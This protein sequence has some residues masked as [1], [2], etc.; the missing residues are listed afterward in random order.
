[1]KRIKGNFVENFCK[2]FPESK[3]HS[4]RQDFEPCYIR[5]GA[6]YAMRRD[7]IVKMKNRE[8]NNSA[9]FI[10]PIEKSI[11]ID[12]K[13]DLKMARTMCENGMNKNFPSKKNFNIIYKFKN[14]RKP[15]LLVTA[16][17]HFLD[18]TKG[19][20]N[21]KYDLIVLK[22]DEKKIVE[23]FL[24]RT[25]IWIC[26]PCP[27]YKIDKSILNIS[28]SLKIIATPS[29]G[30]NHI[31][32]V[33]CKNKNI[34]VIALKGTKFIKSISASSEYTFAM[35]LSSIRKI[36]Q[37]IN[38]VKS[39]YWRDYENL[40]RGNE[41]SN[42]TLGI[43]GYG[44]IG[45]NLARYAKSFKMK[46]LVNDP[47]KK[48]NKTKIKNTNINLLLKNSDVVAVCVHLNDKTRNM[49]N[50][51]FFK[52][53]KKGAIFINSSRGEIV[54]EK[55]LVKYLKNKKIKACFLDVVTNENLEKKNFFKKQIFNYMK[56]N[57]NLHISPHI[58]GLTYESEN[59]AMKSIIKIISNETINT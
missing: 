54:D 41:L 45:S 24:K 10:M 30:S 20:L 33:Y 16:P 47:Y 50:E 59:K 55:I 25:D 14:N 49:V 1:M 38:A 48:F 18:S 3:K 21:K 7:V 46:I 40:L 51:N 23:K 52:K 13:F 44:R 53:M 42:L 27:K 56:Q 35:I 4:R 2:E 8:G 39:N 37:S 43:I 12:E 15:K 26:N 5:N 22:H 32:K 34:K 6:I 28:K 9:P 17:L 19:E 11:N 57:K 31:D 36:P 58:A 29:T